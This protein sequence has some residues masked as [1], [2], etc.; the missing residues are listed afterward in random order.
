MTQ[1]TREA[2][3][4]TAVADRFVRLM[5]SFTRMRSQFLA[6][7]QHNVE[8]SAHIL[9]NYL[10]VEGPMR[11]S[12]LAEHVQSDPS[13]VSRQVAALVRDG[14]VE[15]RADPED[16]RASLLVATDKA[17]QVYADHLAVRDQHYARM[18][19]DWSERDLQEFAQLLGRFTDDLETRQPEWLSKKLAYREGN[20]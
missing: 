7:A 16:G 2:D 4:V 13:T 12:A 6:E 5:R 10:V 1:T 15:R 17:Q 11:S 9:I 20:S 19:E 14:L 18:L 8:W 3:A